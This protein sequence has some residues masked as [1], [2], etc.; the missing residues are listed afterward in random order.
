MKSRRTCA[1]LLLALALA[2]CSDDEGDDPGASPSD[3][4]P[5]APSSSATSVAPATG[6]AMTSDWLDLKL[7]AEA[8]WIITR[9][10]RSGHHPSEGG[11]L[12]SVLIGSAGEGF[13]SLDEVSRTSLSVVRD[14]RPTATVGPNRTVAGVEGITITAEDDR[15]Y[16]YVFDTTRDGLEV[17]ISFQFPVKDAAAEGWIESVL[18][19]VEWK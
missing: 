2:G 10:G 17:S 9:N 12:T 11:T 6:Q 7:P 1:A 16:L 15:G 18:A 19:S 3:A 5:S 14:S 8:E 13:D 4:S